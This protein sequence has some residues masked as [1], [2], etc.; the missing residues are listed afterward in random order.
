MQTRQNTGHGSLLRTLG[1]RKFLAG[2]AATAAATTTLGRVRASTPQ[3]V[4]V[5]N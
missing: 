1:R 5:W 4:N 2:A 3:V